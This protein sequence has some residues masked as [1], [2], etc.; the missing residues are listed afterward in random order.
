MEGYILRVT[1]SVILTYP[2]TS[3][4]RLHTYVRFIR[5]HTITHA[6]TCLHMF[7]TCFSTLLLPE[8]ASKETLKDQLLKAIAECEGFGLE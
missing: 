3:H 2:P 4:T 7:Y 5:L 1:P 8:Y 6:H